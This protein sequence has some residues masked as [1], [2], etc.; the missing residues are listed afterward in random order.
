MKYIIA[1]NQCENLL[2]CLLVYHAPKMFELTAVPGKLYFTQRHQKSYTTYIA[3]AIKT[4]MSLVPTFC[5][6]ADWVIMAVLK[7]SYL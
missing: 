5:F 1:K 2:L 3:S 4:Q 7:V 6:S